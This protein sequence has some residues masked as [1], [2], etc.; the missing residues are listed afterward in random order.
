MAIWGLLGGETVMLR[1]LKVAN[2]RRCP[3]V[4]VA[5]FSNSSA[6]SL[7]GDRC[8]V[9]VVTGDP[10]EEVGKFFC[11]LVAGELCLSCAPL[12]VVFN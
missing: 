2:K 12:W 3:R 7:S 5:A 9:A 10:G 8:P 11:C 1:R 6:A 4:S